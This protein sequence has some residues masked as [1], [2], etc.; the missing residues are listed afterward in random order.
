M[1]SHLELLRGA[2]QLTEEGGNCQD[3]DCSSCSP[4]L[5]TSSQLGGF[6]LYKFLSCFHF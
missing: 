2:E 4:K 3:S 6:D 1:Q 5:N